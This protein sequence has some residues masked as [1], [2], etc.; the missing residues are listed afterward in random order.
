MLRQT[1]LKKTTLDV[2]Q[3]VADHAEHLAA[4][5]EAAK[6]AAE[7]TASEEADADGSTTVDLE[8]NAVV[9]SEADACVHD[10][11]TS[12]ASQYHC[13]DPGVTSITERRRWNRRVFQA[14]S[15]AAGGSTVSLVVE[16][17]LRHLDGCGRAHAGAVHPHG[18]IA[19]GGTLGQ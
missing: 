8:P 18:S 3:T 4:V 19:L 16:Y 1:H 14:W 10:L 13:N 17:A 15:Q 9:L 7:A 12:F 6:A 2:Q 5:A 11:C